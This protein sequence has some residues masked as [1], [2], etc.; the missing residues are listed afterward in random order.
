MP[1]PDK[2]RDGYYYC[3]LATFWAYEAVTLEDINF[4]K[5]SEAIFSQLISRFFKKIKEVKDLPLAIN[6]IDDAFKRLYPPKGVSWDN[7]QILNTGT[8]FQGII[9][10]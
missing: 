2:L 4:L 3:T 10:N 5:P 9:T 8:D 6:D 7:W 1:L